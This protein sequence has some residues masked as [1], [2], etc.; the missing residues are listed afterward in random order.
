M[1]FSLVYKSNLVNPVGLYCHSL[2]MVWLN[3]EKNPPDFLGASN[4]RL[5][6]SVTLS[7]QIY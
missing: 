6:N 5:V 3:P 7:F 4:N 1:G 2:G